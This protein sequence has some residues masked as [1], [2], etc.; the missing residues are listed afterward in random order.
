LPIINEAVDL[1]LN[2]QIVNYKY[3]KISKQII[4]ND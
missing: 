1:I 3:N 2:G 4:E